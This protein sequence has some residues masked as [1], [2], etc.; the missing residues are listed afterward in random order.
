MKF[1]K[2]R[3]WISFIGIVLVFFTF[4][5]LLPVGAC[6]GF[7]SVGSTSDGGKTMSMKV[8]QSSNWLQTMCV[9]E[10][11]EG[12]KYLGV[13][14]YTR[15]LATGYGSPSMLI[16]EK[17][18]SILTLS[19]KSW[20]NIP[21]GEGIA[22]PEFGWEVLPYASDAKT[23]VEMMGKLH[24]E[25]GLIHKGGGDAILV[26][27][28]HEFYNMEMTANHWAVSDPITD[29]VFA[30]ANNYLL[31][32]LEKYDISYSPSAGGSS[33]VDRQR[34]AEDLLSSQTEYY[35]GSEIRKAKVSPLHFMK[36]SRDQEREAELD[37]RSRG[38]SISICSEGYNSRTVSAILAIGD[39]N[40]PDML[41]VLWVAIDTPT[42]SPFIPFYIGITE[43]HQDF[44]S[45]DANLKFGR[46]RQLVWENPDYRDLVTSTWES[47][48][49]RTFLRSVNIEKEVATLIDNG[50][51][52]K[53]HSLLTDFVHTRCTE[54]LDLADGLID[55]IEK[56][57]TLSEIVSKYKEL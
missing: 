28:P 45:T 11:K 17:G 6:T 34:R 8:R 38:Q 44:E 57:R 13:E 33:S 53:A 10:P 48:E 32:D 54:A 46:L 22:I 49:L 16:N 2:T 3:K 42:M 31:E 27:D 26:A 25:V 12:Y 37:Y 55:K 5:Y 20:D 50:E 23:A 51:K 43:L 36:F 24:D 4:V 29:G 21:E 14:L 52:D 18:V 19:L 35:V 15:R 39:K 56:E 41:S 7:V 40:Y 1:F 9:V 47:F 30:R